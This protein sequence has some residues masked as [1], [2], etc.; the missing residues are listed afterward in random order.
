MGSL[1]SPTVS[2]LYMEHSEKKALSTTS[3]PKLWMRYVDETFVIQQKGH[4]KTSWIILIKWIQPS[5]LQLRGNK[6]NDIFLFL[7]TLVKPEAD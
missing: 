2:N 6:E 5:S 4:N 3:T 1:V 7:D